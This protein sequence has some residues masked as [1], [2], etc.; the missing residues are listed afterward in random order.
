[1][2]EP[3]ELKLAA[4]AVVAYKAKRWLG[5]K[6]LDRTGRDGYSHR[7]WRCGKQTART[8]QCRYQQS[9]R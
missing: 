5:G 6:I 2:L 3:S 8:C 7:R 4:D 1:M 9:S